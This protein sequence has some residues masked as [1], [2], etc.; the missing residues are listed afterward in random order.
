MQKVVVYSESS[1]KPGYQKYRVTK[2]KNNQIGNEGSKTSYQNIRQNRQRLGRNR[3]RYRYQ[4]GVVYSLS[5]NWLTKI[6]KDQRS[7]GEQM[8]RLEYLNTGIL[9][10]L[11]GSWEVRKD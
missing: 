6:G 8:H 2:Q 7:N 9:D 11:R 5:I 4:R 3:Y 10:T 1:R